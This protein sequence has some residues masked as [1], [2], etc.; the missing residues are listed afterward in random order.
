MRDEFLPLTRP[1]IDEE[2]IA[3]V[4][5][6]LRSG[7]ITTGAKTRQ[8]E[9]Q[10]CELNGAKDCA[11]VSSGSAGMHLVLEALDIGDGDEV[12]TPS[13]TWVSTP[14]LVLLE[15]AKP[16]F[17][18][19]D[20]H[21]LMVTRETLEP[22]LTERT[23]LVVP[24]HFAGAALDLAPIRALCN[25][26]GITMVEDSA[27][28]IGS[29]Y[30][31]EAIGRHGT[32]VFS[33]QA[34]K[35]VTTAEGGL[36]CSDDVAFLERVRRLRFHGLAASAYDRKVQGR[37][38]QAEVQ[39]PGFKYNLP[40]IAAALGLGQLARLDSL[41]ERRR[42]IAA[43]YTRRL[44]EIE[45]L[46]PLGTPS[47]PFKHSWHLFVVR[48]DIESAGRSRDA[49]MEGLKARNIGTGIHFRAV[50]QQ[51]YYR[52]TLSLPQG[53]LPNTEWNSERIMS[54]PLSAQMGEADVDDV[55]DAIKQELRR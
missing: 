24:V 2:D 25:E 37:A 5:A 14:N 36:I 50:H 21:T 10:V 18:D 26:R 3:A 17:A 8:L 12:V 1:P 31:G 35:N 39:E 49:F 52:E 9:E 7:W 28:A 11:A 45:E 22:C 40:D 55:V 47:W 48:L 6:V 20:R 19:V 16:V 51:K 44:E 46:S 33:L 38:P 23:R 15:G 42:Q 34:I 13:M 53:S 29:E 27:H 4:T 43:Y 54:L 32:S 41:I 30:R